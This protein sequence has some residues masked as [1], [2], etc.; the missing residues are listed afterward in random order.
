ML[1]DGVRKLDCSL[2]WSGTEESYAKMVRNRDFTTITR[3][4]T[5]KKDFHITVI[6]ATEILP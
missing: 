2:K 3:K 6:I 5:Q 4:Q 1:E